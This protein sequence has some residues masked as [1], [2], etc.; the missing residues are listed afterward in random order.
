MRRRRGGRS[1]GSGV[2]DPKDELVLASDTAAAEACKATTRLK[3]AKAIAR[4]QLL[5][6]YGIGDY[7]HAKKRQRR[8]FD[9]AHR[10]VAEGELGWVRGG[11][12]EAWRG[13]D[14]V[15]VLGP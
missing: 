6:H 7:M 1:T 13:S 2:R 4:Q 10:G 5:G 14:R 9:A 8:G 11:R 12:S 3:T 15:M